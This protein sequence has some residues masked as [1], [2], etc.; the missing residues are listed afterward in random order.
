ML[1]SLLEFKKMEKQNK[2]VL[3]GLPSTGKWKK[4]NQAVLQFTRLKRGRKT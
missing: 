1:Q 4:Q 3:K 2:A